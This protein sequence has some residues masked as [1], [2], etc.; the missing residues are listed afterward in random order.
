M[1]CLRVRLDGASRPALASPCK[2]R[3]PTSRAQASATGFAIFPLWRLMPFIRQ[4]LP[5]QSQKLAGTY[6]M[7]NVWKAFR[8]RPQLNTFA[9][10]LYM[11]QKQHPSGQPERSERESSGD[12]FL[13]RL[14]NLGF[15]NGSSP[16]D[17]RT[18]KMWVPRPFLS[19]GSGQ[20]VVI[21][22]SC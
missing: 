5:N 16:C 1:P 8:K 10:P 20:A 9:P 2:R 3:M 19:G 18:E 17:H 14:P 15:H 22:V 12:P 7:R 4:R 11:N 21:V 13:R 6:E